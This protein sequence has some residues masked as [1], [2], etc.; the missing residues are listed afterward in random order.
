MFVSK[1]QSKSVPL[2]SILR[3]F[4]S[5]SIKKLTKKRNWWPLI[6][7]SASV[8][9]LANIFSVFGFQLPDI[10]ENR[11]LAARPT[12][13]MS[14][15]E[16]RTLATRTEAYLT[17][18]FPP[19]PYMIGYLNYARYLL[20]Y[21]G[22]SKVVV[23]K[24]G[25]LFYN[26]GSNMA[27]TAGGQ[28]LSAIEMSSWV[29]GFQQRVKYV[30]NNGAKFYML[31]GPVKEDIFPE[32]RPAWMPSNRVNTEVDDFIRL[33]R[34]VSLDQIVDPR[35]ALLASKA[36]AI[37]WHKYDTHWTGLGAYEGYK[38]LMNRISRDIPDLKP[39]PLSSFAPSRLTLSQIPRDL[40][41]M[42]GISTF[43]PHEGISYAT[44]P[45]HDPKRTEFL[46]ERKDWTAP[47]VL[48][49]DSP[50]GRTLVLMRDS[51]ATELLTFLKPHFSK[52]VM[53]HVQDGFFRLDL[54]DRFKP[55]VVVLEVIETGARHS[56]N[57]LPELPQ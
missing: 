40:S 23:G 5:Q 24:D 55:D 34:S 19:R 54:I 56:M 22:S 9:L 7:S 46:S 29:K 33:T 49:T 12:F 17:D 44:F 27:F 26:D 53:S 50:T 1:Q 21:S 36:N 28:R 38:A 18:N 11:V 2:F 43:V 39:L 42:L 20:G 4:M 31:P 35:D 45:L 6:I 15:D 25:W 13:P 30:E 47:Q 32:Y 57:L 41:L 48:N 52:I 10:Q 51:F 8:V 37:I 16:V 3:N 14:R